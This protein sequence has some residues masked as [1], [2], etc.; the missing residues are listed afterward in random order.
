MIV[1]PIRITHGRFSFRIPAHSTTYMQHI[2]YNNIILQ[3][4]TYQNVD[5]RYY[6]GSYVTLTKLKYWQNKIWKLNYIKIYC[7]KIFIVP[8]FTQLHA[9]IL[10]IDS[11]RVGNNRKV[12]KNNSRTWDE[13]KKLYYTYINKNIILLNWLNIEDI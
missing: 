2:I 12:P 1:V 7:I 3:I 8:Y 13:N 4:T 5:G 9:Q 10:I 6:I 11:D